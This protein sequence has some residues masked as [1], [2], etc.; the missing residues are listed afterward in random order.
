MKSMKSNYDTMSLDI[1]DMQESVFSSVRL[2][3]TLLVILSVVLVLL[4]AT[5]ASLSF[6]VMLPYVTVIL[7]TGCIGK[8][9]ERL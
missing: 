1:T 4:T 2:E 9:G 3:T 7:L 6:K 5:T 8:R